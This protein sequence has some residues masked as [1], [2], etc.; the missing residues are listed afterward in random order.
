MSSPREKEK[1]DKEI[2]EETKERDRGKRGTRMKVKKQKKIRQAFPNC[3]PIS[4][5]RPDEVRYRTPSPTRPA[6]LV[7]YK[8]VNWR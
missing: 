6:P 4:V 8:I 1:R 5:G 7:V 3:K 2:V